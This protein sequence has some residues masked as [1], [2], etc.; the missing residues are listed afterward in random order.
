MQSSYTAYYYPELS[1][2]QVQNSFIIFFLLQ[3]AHTNIPIV[4]EHYLLS[5]LIKMQKS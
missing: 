1:K 5:E 4:S 2:F 3:F